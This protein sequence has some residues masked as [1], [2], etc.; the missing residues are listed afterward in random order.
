MP[1][2]FSNPAQSLLKWS[3]DS[4]HPGAHLNA[5]LLFGRASISDHDGNHFG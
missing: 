4:D 3:L 1:V 5:A 2:S